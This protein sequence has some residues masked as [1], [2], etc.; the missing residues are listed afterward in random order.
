MVPGDA[1][2]WIL[3]NQAG[4]QISENKSLDRLKRYAPQAKV[5]ADKQP[6]TDKPW[7]LLKW[8]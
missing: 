6:G 5:C 3:M 8:H 2:D 1:S 4:N 7:S